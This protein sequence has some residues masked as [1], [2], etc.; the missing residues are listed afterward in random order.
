MSLDNKVVNLAD[1]KV[2][3]DYLLEQDGLL[4]DRIDELGSGIDG[5]E[6]IIGD[7]SNLD[8]TLKNDI[9][10]AINEVLQTGGKVKSVNGKTG[11]V[12]LKTSDLTNDSGYLT[13]YT[14][15]DPTVPSWAKQPSKPTY[16]AQEVG[17]TSI[18][19]MNSEVNTRRAADTQLQSQ[20]T[21][22]GNG[23]PIPVETAAEMID[24]TKAY[25]YTG[26][27]AGWLTGCWYTYDSTQAKFV[28]RGEYGAGVIIDNTLTVT[29]NA[30]DAKATG[31]AISEINGRLQ[32]YGNYLGN[33][34]KGTFS[35]NGR[36]IYIPYTFENGKTYRIALTN[37]IETV[38]QLRIARSKTLATS[39]LITTF[40]VDGKSRT[41]EWECTVDDAAYF[42]VICDASVTYNEATLE[43]IDLGGLVEE[44]KRNSED[45]E[46]AKAKID[47]LGVVKEN[48][49]GITERIGLQPFFT[50][51][52][53]T[54]MAYGYNKRIEFDWEIGYISNGNNLARNYAI[55]T[56][57]PVEIA[58]TLTITRM[59]TAMKMWYVTYSSDG[60]Y[61]TSSASIVSS[62]YEFVPVSGKKYRFVISLIDTSAEID[63][64]EGIKAYSFYLKGDFFNPQFYNL[65]PYVLFNSRNVPKFVPVSSIAIK[66]VFQSGISMYARNVDGFTPV[67]SKSF[68]TEEEYTCNQTNVLVWNVNDNTV[69]LISAGDLTNRYIVLFD[70]Q[71][72][73]PS[74]GALMPYY[75]QQQKALI[76]Y[77][78]PPY[79]DNYLPGKIE[80]VRD[81]MKTVGAHGD[82]FIFVTDTHWASNQKK[83]PALVRAIL[84]Q[85]QIQKVV[86]GGDIPSAYQ[87]EENMYEA[88]RGEVEAW[89]YAVGD[90]LYRVLGNHDIHATDRTD[91]SNPTYYELTKNEVY[92]L[93]MKG[94]ENKVNYNSANLEGMYYYFDNKPQKIR[95]ICLNNFETPNQA[96]MSNYQ[97]SWVGDRV[98]ELES[99]WSVVFIGHTSIIP[100]HSRASES[101]TDLRGLITAIANKTTFTTSYSR[102]FDF[103]GKDTVVIGYFAGHYHQDALDVVDGVTYCVTT[104]DALFQDDGY[105]RVPN[106][107]NEQAFDIISIDTANKHVY[108][109][110]I[111]AGTD[112]EFSYA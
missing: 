71:Y 25:L 90:K 97:V 49:D 107:V 110:R 98:L 75:L 36:A 94:Q 88:V 47:A 74:F 38:T 30:A 7:L 1:L 82:S 104:C 12:V 62:K 76:T 51:Y 78:Y 53:E 3:H 95:Y 8:T 45:I 60:T 61:E 56:K 35:S 10:S 39:A 101:L 89:N 32:Q 73:T 100:A 58:D 63:L 69:S 64:L 103:T 59:S 40:V 85:S 66:V 67:L 21:A 14:E 96:Y 105:G 6:S 18:E 92:G 20:I 102:T 48:I 44:S 19:N 17:A 79:Y 112:R 41:A 54:P 57:E 84:A 86:H 27:E 34:L 43:I 11:D 42:I 70:C 80:T 15:T 5:V 9:V 24:N 22:L 31:D 29:G 55:R 108:L 26:A 52:P 4:S 68:A 83:S 91:A 16:T 23:A 65:E 50:N 37:S 33:P 93:L 109:T 13:S 81:R 77:N 28:P 106:T 46:S 72:G 2:S 99:G 87:T 111:G